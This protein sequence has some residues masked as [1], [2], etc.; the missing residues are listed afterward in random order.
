MSKV[1]AGG[2]VKIT[3]NVAGKRLGVKKYAGEE[4]INGNMIVRQRGTVFHPG[5]NTKLSND[6]SIYAIADGVVSFR[7][8]TGYK[9]NQYYV[10]VLVKED[11]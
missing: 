8:M 11:K 5:R 1:A 7:R 2:A 6:H 4:V 3:P 9:R 10:D